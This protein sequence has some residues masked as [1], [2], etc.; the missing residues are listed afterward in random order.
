MLVAKP[1]F[2]PPSLIAANPQAMIPEKV[3]IDDIRAWE[4]VIPKRMSGN[5]EPLEKQPELRCFNWTDTRGDRFAVCFA[6]D[7]NSARR[8][9]LQHA[10]VHLC[11]LDKAERES[12]G[13][14][15]PTRRISLEEYYARL[16]VRAM[17]FSRDC[18]LR[19][20]SQEQYQALC[21]EQRGDG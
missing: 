3:R 20:L 12:M 5:E 7:S 14:S 1:Q 9:V 15:L 19:E 10:F 17:K 18:V 8:Y 4:E 21:A 13:R 6:K 2:I 16:R 11:E